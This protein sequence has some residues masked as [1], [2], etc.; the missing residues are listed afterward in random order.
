MRLK[1]FRSAVI[2]ENTLFN[3]NWL[4]R[5][6]TKDNAAGKPTCENR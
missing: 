6:E 5:C 2:A 3:E 4:K 1:L